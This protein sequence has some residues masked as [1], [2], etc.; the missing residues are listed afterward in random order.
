MLCSFF[1]DEGTAMVTQR[2]MSTSQT[3]HTA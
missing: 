1:Q 2:S 3:P